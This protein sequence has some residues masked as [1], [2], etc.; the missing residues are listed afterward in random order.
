MGIFECIRMR[1]GISE[2]EPYAFAACIL[3]DGGGV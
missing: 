1:E 3:D 2:P